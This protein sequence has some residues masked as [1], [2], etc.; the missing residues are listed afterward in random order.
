MSPVAIS[1]P[2]ISV[3]TKNAI[4]LPTKHE[5]TSSETTR[6]ASSDLNQADAISG[7]MLKISRQAEPEKNCPN[8][9]T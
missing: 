9:A 8:R 3:G 5:Q 7:G 1:F 2:T 6:D 4:E